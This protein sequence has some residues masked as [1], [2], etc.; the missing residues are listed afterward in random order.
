MDSCSTNVQLQPTCVYLCERVLKF[1]QLIRT[2]SQLSFA[3]RT[4]LS[5]Q[6][7]S[8]RLFFWSIE[9]PTMPRHIRVQQSTD[10]KVQ[11]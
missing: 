5:V 2:K 11:P 1:A 6:E 7:R 3:R 4:L 8:E 9:R 10:P